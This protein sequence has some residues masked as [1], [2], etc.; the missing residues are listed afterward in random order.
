MRRWRADI[1]KID[2]EVEEY[3]MPEK[4]IKAIA[5]QSGTVNVVEIC[6]EVLNGYIPAYVSSYH[7]KIASFIKLAA[8]SEAQK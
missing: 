1:A 2:R 6:R 4:V 5:V 8:N 3:V 7:E